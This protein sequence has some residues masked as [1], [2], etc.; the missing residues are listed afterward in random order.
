MRRMIL[1]VF[2]LAT[3]G[4]CH[5]R[6]KRAAPDID[7]VRMQVMSAN[8]PT[9][10]VLSAPE[11][12]LA[13]VVAVVEGLETA[14]IQRKLNR[15]VDVDKMNAAFAEGLDEALGPGRPFEITERKRA[16][17]LQ[18][19]V[20][21][22][23]V[24]IPEVG[25]QGR[26]VYDLRVRL[27]DRDGRRVY[28]T[29]LSCDTPVGD[30]LAVSKALGTVNNAKQVDEMRRKE[31]QDAFDEAAWMCGNDLVARMRQHASPGVFA[32]LARMVA[33]GR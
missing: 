18:V 33:D 31:I 24:E 16:P 32:D 15:V 20:V 25:H 7:R 1:G 13:P 19:E 28:S 12:D 30:P 10:E 8:R 5:A 17:L 29:R 9:V 4:G 3:L 26:F 22:Y 14:R 27:Y 11:G 2:F 6:W 21:D 23:G